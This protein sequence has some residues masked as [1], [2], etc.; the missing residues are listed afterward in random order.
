METDY[1]LAAEM[2]VLYKAE[3][4][5]RDSLS[6]REMKERIANLTEEEQIDVFKICTENES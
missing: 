6:R 4:E 3:Q 2:Y 1:Q 5:G